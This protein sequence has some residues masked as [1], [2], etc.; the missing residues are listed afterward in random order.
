MFIELL[1]VL[2]FFTN[3]FFH[4]AS[5]QYILQ[6]FSTPYN[7]FNSVNVIKLVAIRSINEQH[8]ELTHL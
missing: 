5:M 6:V 3:T 4:R 8:P 1:F 7:Y 2:M